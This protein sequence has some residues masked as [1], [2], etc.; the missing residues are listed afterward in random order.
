MRRAVPL[1]LVLTLCA[2]SGLPLNSSTAS[3]VTT[4]SPGNTTLSA[5]TA[6]VALSNAKYF[7]IVLQNVGQNGPADSANIVTVSNSRYDIVTIDEVTTYNSPA[8]LSAVSIVNQ[9]HATTGIS[10]SRKIV[11]AY[12]DIGEAENTRLYWQPSWSVGTPS[13]ILGLDPNG[14]PNNFIVNYSDPRWQQIVF[15]S[16]TAL[17]DQAMADGFDGVFLDNVGAYNYPSV[18][19]VDRNAQ[20]D[21][22]SFVVALSAYAKN[23]NPNFVITANGGAALTNDSRLIPAIDADSEEALFYGSS[24][25]Q[26][27]DI[28]TDS[29]TRDQALTYIQRIQSANK[30]VISIDFATNPQDVALAYAGGAANRLIEYVT[31]RSLNQLT[32]TPSG[33]NSSS[34]SRQASGA[35][36]RN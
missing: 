6:P 30:P 14:Y 19:L 21:M 36:S 11:L 13:F 32:T 28:Q 10:G 8:K 17:V 26:Q 31:T 29:G 5:L 27:G 12:V 20:T 15:G 34:L 35:A 7:A 3:P 23:K 22:V 33:V 4:T 24:S 1:A 9:M 18:A 16:P 25:S 2:C